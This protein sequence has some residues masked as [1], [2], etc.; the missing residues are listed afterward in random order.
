M[1]FKVYFCAV[2]FKFSKMKQI[3]SDEPVSKWPTKLLHFM[4]GK[5]HVFP[6]LKNHTFIFILFSMAIWLAGCQPA[7]NDSHNSVDDA[8]ASYH[9]LFMA[10][11]SKKAVG[12]EELIA[13]VQEWRKLEVAISATMERDTTAHAGARHI[14][15]GD[16][17]NIQMSHLID[18]RKWSYSDYLTVVHGLNDIEMD[19]MSQ[20]LVASVHLFYHDAGTAAPFKG[21]A[22]EVIG[23][24]N[25][26]LDGSLAKG[27]RT[28]Q[29]VIGFLRKEDVA[30]RSFLLHLPTLSTG[31]I[32][33]D[34]ITKKTGEIM[35]GIISL[36]ADEHPVFGKSEV[37]ILLAMRNNRRLLQN[38]EA[39]LESLHRLHRT[40]NGQA[41]AY[42]W[43]ILQ[44]WISLDGF[45][46]ALMND[47]QI[48]TMEKLAERTP[49]ALA[50]LEGAD[51]PLD[52]DGLPTL[53][54]KTFI[55]GYE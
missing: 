34:G 45:A 21:S 4:S 53:L 37:A 28:K 33:L 29:N 51:F 32:S 13:L 41:T 39:C 18:S 40:D 17:I 7:S 16:S 30:F 22:K 43:M 23:K 2:K 25:R 1:V 31:N 35:H 42:Q 54:I 24:Y 14:S 44:P 27:I 20:K 26:L 3:L 46:Y 38:A 49:E 8:L 50:K 5:C 10:I 52:A 11:K 6:T 19:S 12:V 9:E 36:S 15:L 48:R 47:E 55:L